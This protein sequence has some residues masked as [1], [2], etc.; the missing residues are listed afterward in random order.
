MKE[1]INPAP[2]SVR[3]SAAGHDVAELLTTARALTEP[4]L[5]A[6]IARMHPDSAVV[7]SYHLGWTDE[8]GAAL[9]AV[10]AAGGKMI[11]A[12]LAVCGAVAAGC[13]ARA[14]VPGAAAVELMHNFSLLHDD[15]MDD[16]ARRRGRPSAWTVFGIGPAL[17]A[18]DALF[19][20]SFSALADLGTPE[21]A[22]AARRLG[23]AAHRLSRG[24]AA[25]LAFEGRPW[26][27]PD[28][29]GDNEYLAM[30]EDKTG[31]LFGCAAAVGATV[32]GA[33]AP[34]VDLLDR[35]GRH[36]GVAFQLA[37]DMAELSHDPLSAHDCQYDDLRR[38]KKTFPV[39]SALRAGTAESRRLADLLRADPTDP[40]SL[41]RAADLIEESGARQQAHA[42]VRRH[43][44]DAGVLT[45]EL[46]GSTRARTDL[47]ALI[48]A[49]AA[50]IGS[51]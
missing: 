30:T 44:A 51:R 47:L 34:V 26:T 15:I 43:L 40:V 37:D 35:I 12:G 11:R 45:R 13:G 14:S 22:A 1:T 3:A 41:R 2:P 32:A 48:T 42:L 16:D 33:A 25:D 19:A 49:S 8:H 5:R 50:L 18:G 36:V 27:G 24:Q 29:V 21:G 23:S 10:P 7:A 6:A 4:A 20:L 17:L 9:A 28:A 39:I 31:A 46:S 38:R